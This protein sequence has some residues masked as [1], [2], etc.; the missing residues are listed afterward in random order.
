MKWHQKGTTKQRLP[1]QHSIHN[2]N[3][4]GRKPFLPSHWAQ[5]DD[6]PHLSSCALTFPLEEIKLPMKGRREEKVQS[7]SGNPKQHQPC[8]GRGHCQDKQ[9]GH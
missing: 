3:N 2:F 9:P 1:T 5:F 7:L 4:F 6:N 8:E